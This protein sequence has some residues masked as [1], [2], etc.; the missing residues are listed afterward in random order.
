MIRFSLP[1]LVTLF[2]L[3]WGV[4]SWGFSA[5]PNV[6]ILFT[7]DQRADTIGALG[8]KHIKSP[9]LDRLVKRGISFDR[10][11]MQG[12]RNGATC[13]PS[14]AMLLSGQNLFRIDEQL[15]RDETWPA[16]FGKAGY[17]TFLT[18]K[19]HN[20]EKSIAKSFQEARGVF[21][22]G[23]T[24]PLKAKLSELSEGKL[25]APQMVN[26]HA[27][28][29]FSDEAI[30]FI[31]QNHAKPFFCY[32]AFDGPHDP[33]IVPDDYPLKYDPKTIPL[34]ANFLPQH[35]FNNGEMV[36]RD[37]TLLSWPRKPEEVQSM[38]A[39]YYRYISY[40][41]GEIGRILDALERSPHG[42]NT[43]IVFAGDSGVARGSH[44]LIGKQNCYEHSL[45]VPLIVAGPGI[46]A[47]ERTQSLCFLYD[48]LPTIGKLCGIP[49]PINSDGIDFS[50]T[51]NNP[52]QPIRPH[53]YLGYKE[54]QRAV[55]NEGWKL[56]RYPRVDKTQLFDLQNDPGEITN[57]ADTPEH[58]SKL[59]EL[60][61][62]MET[63]QKRYGDKAPL[64][65]TNPM[66]AEWT[67]PKPR[68]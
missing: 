10:A 41:D 2:A 56:I 64:K 22:G 62:L 53:L 25:K 36:I 7:D 65:V 6:L 31:N 32:V 58:A 21:S 52:R 20:G 49:K 68:Q 40:L 8:N 4:S 46:N 30:S 60:M 51:L 13:V 37:E 9:N 57:L 1:V 27:C 54:V 38:L 26:Q 28:A 67:P 63:D 24:N 12:G 45:R 34:P 55:I 29:V 19:W 15:M 5:S 16:A 33:H 59:R 14:R 42:K 17:S 66:S 18:G 48:V 47:N 43:I 23:M 44:G 35:P 11:Y 39:D 61:Q 3:S 50:S